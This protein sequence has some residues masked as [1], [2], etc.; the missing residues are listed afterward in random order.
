MIIDPSH[1]APDGNPTLFWKELQDRYGVE[2]R[3]T[4]ELEPTEAHKAFREHYKGD[5]EFRNGYWRHVKERF[6]FQEELM[7]KE[8]L[9]D[10]I[11]MEYDILLYCPIEF[12]SNRLRGYAKGRIAYGMDTDKRGHPGFIFFPSPDA[13]A[14]LNNFFLNLVKSPFEDMQTL[15]LYSDSNPDRVATLPLITP[16][17]N[18]SI[19]PRKSLTNNTCED[20]EF[21]CAGFK[22][23]GCL[24]DSL[25]V[26]QCIGGI[27]P[28]NSKG[29]NTIGFINESAL[30]SLEEM[31]FGWGK[32]GNLWLPILDGQP[33]V[34]IHLHSKALSCFLSDRNEMPTADYD[35][36]ALKA[37][38]EP[39]ERRA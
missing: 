22:E 7:R 4:D 10:M 18:A 17:R 27:D 6:F 31:S 5:T 11:T 16:K 35:I 19:T 13:A 12:I 36:V 3:F 32:I 23:M 25:S 20:T 33:L 29:R 1:R 34:T 26:G 24:F 2:L 15:A 38:L 8:G 21:L 30:Y 9:N 28:R 14:D 37:S 39:N